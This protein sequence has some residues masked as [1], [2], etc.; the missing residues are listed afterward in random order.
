MRLEESAGFYPFCLPM[1][2]IGTPCHWQKRVVVADEICCS[3]HNIFIV[4]RG[5]R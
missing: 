2:Y 4:D 3:L 5:D 1:G